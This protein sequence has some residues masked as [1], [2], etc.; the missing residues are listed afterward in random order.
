M[1]DLVHS[2]NSARTNIATGISLEFARLILENGGSVLLADL[3][4]RPESESMIAKYSGMKGPKALFRKTDV[5]SWKELNAMFAVAVKEFG[6]IDIVCPGAGVFEPRASNFWLP[7]GTE[8]SADIPDGDRY[9]TVD[10]NLIHPIRVTQLAIQH[11]FSSSPPASSA[12]P[13]SIIHICSV[14]SQAAGL[15]FPLY[16][17]TKHGLDGFVRSMGSLE[18]SNGIRVTAVAPG[19]VRTPLFT[20]QPDKLRMLDEDK[21]DWVDARDVAKVMFALIEKNELDNASIFG[22]DRVFGKPRDTISIQGGT[23]LEVLSGNIRD[24]PL[25]GNQGP[26]SSGA[27]GVNTSN[28]KVV[29]TELLETLRPGWGT[30]AR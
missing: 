13:K 17:A 9:N 19:A 26:S 2:Y 18:A 28:A 23:V 6:T 25:F 27:P 15:L 10:I 29:Y 8:L 20:E 1:C 24:V 16:I 12:N 7:P 3:Q 22:H 21:D 11:F 5:T 14:A 4:L 30:P